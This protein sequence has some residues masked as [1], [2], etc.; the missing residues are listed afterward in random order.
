[1][2]LHLGSLDDGA[3]TDL[4]VAAFGEVWQEIPETRLE[5]F[6]PRRD[7]A[8]EQGLTATL[9]AGA[10]SA[11][12]FRVGEPGA[13]DLCR[14]VAVVQPL[15]EPRLLD[16]LVQ[17][18][19][20]ARPLVAAR[21]AATARVLSAPGICYPVG[22][23][24]VSGHFEPDARMIV[25]AMANLLQ[26]PAKARDLAMRARAHV[27]THLVGGRPRPARRRRYLLVS[28]PWW[29]WRHH[30]SKPRRRRC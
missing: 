14:A 21:F 26:E 23:R 1:M 3:G 5:V 13:E 9:S 11:L 4:A 16:F 25:W 7:V 28:G 15:R 17:V 24:H 22:G 10:R 29:C 18:M 20:S 19:A 2:F 30:C 8:V 12:S 6:L 27:R